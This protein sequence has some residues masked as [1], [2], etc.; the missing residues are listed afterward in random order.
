[1][2]RQK[3]KCCGF[4]SLFVPDLNKYSNQCL[5][6]PSSRQA[7]KDQWL[8]VD[9]SVSGKN[10]SKVSGSELVTLEIFFGQDWRFYRKHWSLTACLDDRNL[11]HLLF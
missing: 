11:R 1:M 10:I 2:H 3:Y 7:V 5:R 4:D 6:F 8:L 9:L